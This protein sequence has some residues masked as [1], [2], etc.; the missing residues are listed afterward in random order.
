MIRCFENDVV[1]PCSISLPNIFLPALVVASS[2]TPKAWYT[3]T[4]VASF[5]SS[6]V[7]LYAKGDT[8][9]PEDNFI[10]GCDDTGPISSLVLPSILAVLSSIVKGVESPV[11]S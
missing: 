11:L 9:L 7:V 5:V 1:M 10:V 2:G 6:N 8:S 4:L 3:D